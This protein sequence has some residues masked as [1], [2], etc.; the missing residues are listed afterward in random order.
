LK[1]HLQRRQDWIRSRRKK[2]H[3]ARTARLRRQVFRYSVLLC[4]VIAGCAGFT[5]L[6]WSIR[7]AAGDIA[8][9]GNHVASD[10]QIRSLLR[11]AIGEPL[12]TVDPAELGKSVC[13]LPIVKYAFIRRAV[14]PYPQLR[15]E[16]LEEF[17]WAT[18][19]ST[20]DG[21][22]EAVISQTGR[23]IP[24]KD[25]P[26]VV[27]PPLRICGPADLKLT[28]AQIA[29]W[30]SRVRLIAEQLSK[31]VDVVDMRQPNQ[32]VVTCGDTELHIGQ[33]DS[34]MSRR[35]GRIASILPVADTL[36]DKLK[37]IDLSLDSNIPL[38][39]DK[40]AGSAV[41]DDELLRQAVRAVASNE[42]VN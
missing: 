12:Y 13:Q 37:Y 38:K 19:S 23:M 15:V 35:L 28:A 17:P 9:H 41:K 42:R 18:Y 25:F 29:E 2:R 5:Q 40:S 39:V 11:G 31:P 33:A 1:P 34:S 22:P 6:P 26:N 32:I 20:P 21:L 24:I 14:F 36:K 27:Q 16:V 8:I 30:D 4:L 10:D 3:Q 7:N